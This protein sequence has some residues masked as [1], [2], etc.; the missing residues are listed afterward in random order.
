MADERTAHWRRIDDRH[1]LHPF[2]TFRELSAKG[3]RVIVRGEGCYVFDSEGNRLFDGM[4]GLWCV[5]VGYGRERL[6]KAAFE[7]MTRLPYYNTFFQTT[8]PPVAELAARLA[9]ILPA[10]L[11]RVIFGNSGS[12]ANDTAIKSV[13]YYWNLEGRPQKKNIIARSLGYHGVGVGSASLTGMR[14]M[15]EPFDL[16]LAR[17]HHIG[18]PYAFAVGEGLDEETFG[19]TAARWLEDKILELG[20]DTVAAFFAEP[21][22][23]AGGVIIPPASYWPEIQRICRKYDVLLVVDEVIC[24]FGRTGNWWGAT[25]FAIEPDLLVMA[26]G[27]SSGYLPISAVALGARVGDAIW[28]GEKEFAHGLTY[29]G[30]PV[31][32]AVALENIA[33]MEEEGLETR[34]SGPIGRH[35]A[36]RL[37]QLEEH[38]LVG[39]VRTR[40]L[41][42]CI[43]LVEDKAA[44]KPYPADRKVGLTCRD[45]SIDNGLIMR[46]IRDGMVLAPPLIVTEAEVD[47]I[48]EKVSR[49]LDDTARALGR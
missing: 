3:S 25:T 31:A 26:K 40:G 29:A 7:Q 34:A 41:L 36:S 24:G 49:T 12:D 38:P 19:S 47:E 35:F 15:H 28:A 13:W 43:E 2:T 42:A 9:A 44:R 45:I 23:G 21:I 8:T 27:L 4:S 33:I 30:H 5:N 20:A 10:G 17:F 18:N 11:G 32:A 6:A 16:P 39:E 1:H 37:A 46:A 22:Q 14:F 48:V